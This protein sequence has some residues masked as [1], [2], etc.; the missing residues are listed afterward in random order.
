MTPDEFEA[1]LKYWAEYPTSTFVYIN[2]RA[3]LYTEIVA[4]IRKMQ[5]QLVALAVKFAEAK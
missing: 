1:I 2:G 5:S 3:I 4:Y